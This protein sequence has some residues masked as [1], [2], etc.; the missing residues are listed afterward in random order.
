M[1]L[2]HL[3][4]STLLTAALVLTI[5][6]A[7]VSFVRAESAQTTPEAAPTTTDAFVLDYDEIASWVTGG[8]VGMN[9]TGEI[10]I[11]GTDETDEYGIIIFADNN[12]M[13][14]ASFVGQITYNDNYMT[15]TD[16][17]NE[18][19]IT[20]TV[21]DFGNGVLQLDMSDLG[22]AAV[23]AQTKEVVL[24]FIQLAI[25]AYTHVA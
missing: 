5:V 16:E 22:T 20:Y 14:A 21:T 3:A 17:T 25:D 24:N 8:F 18:L 12:T 11:L 9:T 4:K 19:A 23:Q 6:A 7:P 15:I 2:K 1:K 10:V 13:T